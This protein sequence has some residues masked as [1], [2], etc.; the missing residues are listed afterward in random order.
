MA[1][2]D[3]ALNVYYS[4][5]VFNIIIT[6]M[7]REQNKKPGG[8]ESETVLVSVLKMYADDTRLFQPLS[9]LVNVSC[10]WMRPAVFVCVCLVRAERPQ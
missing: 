10:V 1:A 9:E 4:R 5:Q 8:A 3:S 2:A 7:H 6:S